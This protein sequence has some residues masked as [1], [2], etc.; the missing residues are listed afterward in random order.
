[1]K[2][3]AT[4]RRMHF[5]VPNRSWQTVPEIL[6]ARMMDQCLKMTT[7]MSQST[8]S[9]STRRWTASSRVKVVMRL[10]LRLRLMANKTKVE[11]MMGI[12]A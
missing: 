3:P 2:T 4:S 6:I 12:E 1:M 7:K 8:R 10:R 11:V 5:V 9:Q